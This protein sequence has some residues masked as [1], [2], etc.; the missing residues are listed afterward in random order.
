MNE[1][2]ESEEEYRE[3]LRRF[4]DIMENN[5]GQTDEIELLKLIR[6]LELYEYENC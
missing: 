4:I 1:R 2:L 6:L 3:V 5:E